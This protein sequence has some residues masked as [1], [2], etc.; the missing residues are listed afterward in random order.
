MHTA[1]IAHLPALV[2]A[3]PSDLRAIAE[4]LLFVKCVT[5]HTLP[6]AAMEPWI[7]DYFG[8]AAAVRTQ[9]VIRVIN[10]LTLDGA[11]YN[12]LR[13]RRPHDDERTAD[14][15][16]D[17]EQRLE[18]AIAAYAGARDTFRDPLNGT[19]ADPF[20]RIR[21][22]HCLS[23][24]NVAKYD[25]WHGLVIFDEFHPLRFDRAQVRD[26]FDVALRWLAAAQQA[27]LAAQYPLITWNCL[28]KAGASITHGHLQMNLSHGMAH[29]IVE[30]WRRAAETYRERFDGDYHDDLWRVHHALGLGFGTDEQVRSYV[31]LTPMKDRELLLLSKGMVQPGADFADDALRARL[32]ALW[33]A[34]Y[35]ALRNLIDVQGVRSFNLAVYLPPSAPTPEA[36]DAMPVCVRIVDRG[37]PMTRSVNL[38]A[39][40]LFANSVI[41]ADPFEVAAALRFS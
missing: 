23:A 17:A 37:K 6:P 29:G 4:R 34:T 22:R 2:S 31:S 30:R 16:A 36:W 9:T 39:M 7:N 1:S 21:G 20:G 27:D 19:T 40:E 28:W 38:G 33:D 35:A 18:E 32:E 3:L 8:D 5:G 26:Y 41:G 14:A 13:A 11:L 15:A 12:P 10:R 25:G 24:S